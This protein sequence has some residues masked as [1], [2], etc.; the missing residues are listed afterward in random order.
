MDQE[1]Q[2]VMERYFDAYGHTVST[3]TASPATF[4]KITEEMRRC[5]KGERGPLDDSEFYGSIPAGAL[6]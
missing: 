2:D 6:L 1:Q 4:T 5:L 3:V